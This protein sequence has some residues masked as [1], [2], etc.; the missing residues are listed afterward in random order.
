MDLEW[1]DKEG[2]K[3]VE[4]TIVDARRNVVAQVRTKEYVGRRAPKT[5]IEY[6]AAVRNVKLLAAAPAL[7]QAAVRA[8]DGLENMTTDDFWRGADKPLRKLL[9][10]AILEA[11]GTLP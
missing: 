3:A 11:G 8:L 10:D 7:Y 1:I 9:E 4:L 6:P 5:R 2:W